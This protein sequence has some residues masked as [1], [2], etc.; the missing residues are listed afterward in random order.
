MASACKPQL[1]QEFP[2]GIRNPIVSAKSQRPLT[3][4]RLP[5]LQGAEMA[6]GQSGRAVSVTQANSNPV[7]RMARARSL[8]W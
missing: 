3:L 5:K 2:M 8:K 1:W 7:R 4:R 6:V